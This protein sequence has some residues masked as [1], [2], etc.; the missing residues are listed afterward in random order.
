M[1]SPS[2]LTEM[3]VAATSGG[4]ASG[5]S[6]VLTYPLEITKTRLMNKLPHQTTRDVLQQISS[7]SG[8]FQ[9]CPQKVTKSFVQKF[10]YFWL[11]E[12]LLLW[13]YRLRGAR[14]SHTP[15]LLLVGYLSE[16]LGIPLFAPLEYVAVQVQTSRAGDGAV[17][18]V[19]R[20]LREVGLSGFYRGWT[21]Y[22]LCA[23]QP[24]V[25]FAIINRMKQT[26]LGLDSTKALG[27]RHAFWLG[28][29]SKAV[30]STLTYPINVGRVVMQAS[31]GG[32][33][34]N[35]ISV[36]VRIWT[37]EGLQG[38]YKGLPN[39]LSEGLLAAAIQLTIRERITGTVRAAIKT[40]GPL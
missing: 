15:V 11:Y 10:V 40:V 27:S 33:G 3:L 13:W 16:A 7:E 38:W 12:G 30:A 25:Q 29:F 22:L 35:I 6:K 1:A 24:S 8:W 36:L 21:V 31:R 20:T 14:T 2:A 26:L 19:R 9:G 17:A 5:C 32:T 18:V 37:D 23:F 28:A 34:G 39:E 4:V